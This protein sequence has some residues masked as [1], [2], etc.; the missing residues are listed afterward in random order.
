MNTRYEHISIL[1]L[2]AMGRALADALLG[3][4]REV[5]VWNR[6]AGKAGELVARGAK[7]ASSVGEAVAAGDLTVICLLDDASVRETLT[8]VLSDLTGTT[9]VNVTS[10]SVRQAR[11]L[12]G[13]LEG[14]GVRFLAGGIMA[15]PQSVGTP[16]AFILYSGPRDLFDRVA[17][18]LGPMGRA[19]WVGEDAGFAAL[20]DM[21]ALSG[22]YGMGAGT[23]HAVTLV[24]AEGGDLETFKREVL[25]PWLEQM[26]PISVD[27]ADAS[28]SVPDEYNP[29]M[30]AV[31][32]ENLLAASG[33]AGVPAELAGHLSASLWRMRRAV[34]NG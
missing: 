9:L 14:H 21:A 6:S 20:Y 13:W 26:L 2:G 24:H 15:V 16:G 10:G 1:G 28:A 4:G 25:R 34:A 27:G 7:E 5:T 32:L 8:P 30:Q 23:D 19:H 22:M 11:A 33:E 29:A 12:A 18:V 31:G 17:P 3:A